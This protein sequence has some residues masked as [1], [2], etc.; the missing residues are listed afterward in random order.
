MKYIIDTDPGVDDAIAI[1]MA[2]KNNMDIIGL[3]LASGNIPQV[4]SSKNLKIIQDILGSNIKMYKGEHEEVIEHNTAEYA[5]GIDG[6]GYLVYPDTSRR[7]YEGV[8]AEDFIIKASRK[9]KDD[10][11]MICFGSLKNLANAI[12]KDPK[13]VDRIKHVLIMGTTYNPDNKDP[14]ME[15]NVNADPASARLVLESDFEDIKLITHEIGIA[16]HI[17]KNY[18]L[19]L[20][21]SQDKVSRFVGTI[22]EKYMDFSKEKG[23]GDCLVNPDPAT[24]LPA[25]DKSILHFEPCSVKVMDNGRKKGQCYVALTDKSNIKVATTID[26]EKFDKL[27]KSTFK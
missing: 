10:L 13:V 18:V 7:R 27:F 3:T 15:F 4:K 23:E 25:I 26:L 12:K 6:L 21:L 8:R 19:N 11:T 9:Y 14:Y 5:H 16:A 17:D 20:R 1:C 24:L 22:A 2:V